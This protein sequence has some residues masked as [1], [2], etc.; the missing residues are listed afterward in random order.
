[1]PASA[2]P[3]AL[4]RVP[5]TV[6]RIAGAADRST[7]PLFA[8]LARAL[9][10]VELAFGLL[11]TVASIYLQFAQARVAGALWRDEVVSVQ[12]ANMPT[13]G[14]TWRYL[15]FDSYPV[16]F[17]LVLR[18]W[19]AL[20]TAGDVSL[21]ALGLLIGM[22]LLAALWTAGR[23]LGVRVPL[24]ALVLLALNPTVI[25]YGD[26][27]RAYGLG[28]TLAV[29]S[30]AAVWT[31]SRAGRVEWRRVIWAMV[32]GVLSVQCLYHNAAL[33]MAAC[34]GGAVVALW[35][36]RVRVAAASLAVGVPAAVS[37]LPYLPIIHRTRQW[38]VLMKFPVTIPWL[39][40]R[41]TAV[42]GAPDPIGVWLWSALFIGS[43]GLT[44]WCLYRG[45]HGRGR[46]LFAAVALVTATALY[47]GFLFAVGYVTQPWYYLA[48]LAVVGLCL[49][50]VY[51]QAV[52]IPGWRVA[53][54]GVALGFTLLVFDQ[55][56]ATLQV[57]ST[58][59]DLV[60]TRLNE[61]VS[62]RDLVV[63]NRWECAIS[64][65]RYYHGPA[66]MMTVPP[67]EDHAVHRYDLVMQ[68]M[69]SPD[70]LRPVM[71]AVTATLQRGGRV[72]LVGPR[73]ASEPGVALK[74]PAPATMDAAG[75]WHP[76]PNYYDWALQADDFLL[77]HVTDG[78]LVP[79][80]T[81]QSISEFENVPL[82]WFSGWHD[83]G[84]PAKTD[85]ATSP[86]G[87]VFDY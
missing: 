51:G 63:V 68:A 26:S 47:G 76:G 45:S 85:G 62:A 44:G 17:H 19:C 79:I 35:R 46:R 73:L 69:M 67:L 15:E 36:R 7:A 72:W 31:V 12:V 49:D 1:M 27:M 23:T 34:L 43:L 48:L 3:D 75:G 42:T 4:H 29:I 53:R 86:S 2:L 78:A 50:A 55:S 60:A 83:D 59:I 56:R 82:G 39:W 32:A 18:G 37:L 6:P 24:F 61:G 65:N 13:L 9:P 66:R 70:P 58:D 64:L 22:S 41:L 14:Q 8:R 80:E 20:F 11:V 77:R 25:R 74:I 81:N 57:R 33:L 71:D 38:S 5:S 40:S 54:L 30:L 28:C 10:T 84:G 87:A 21:R 16:L 52:S